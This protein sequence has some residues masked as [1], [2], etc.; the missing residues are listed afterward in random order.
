LEDHQIA[1]EDFYQGVNSDE[2]GEGSG[3]ISTI[4]NTPKGIFLIK[5]HQK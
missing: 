4:Q 5:I 3:K 1:R 2:Y